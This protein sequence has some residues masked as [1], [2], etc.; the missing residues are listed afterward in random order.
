MIV[1]SVLNFGHSL[2]QAQALQYAQTYTQTLK[3]SWALYHDA[4]I[5]P[6]ASVDGVQVSPNYQVLQGGIPAP[7][8]Y[9]LHL[10]ERLQTQ[11]EQPQLLLR[12]DYPFP[13]RQNNIESPDAFQ[14][15][16]LDYLIDHPTDNFFQM[17]VAD[18]MATL[19]YAEPLVMEAS[20]VACHNTH[21]DSPRQNWQVGMVSGILTVQQ[22][23]SGIRHWVYQGTQQIGVLVG[24]L[25]GVGIFGGMMVK[26]EGEQAWQRLRDEVQQKT[27]A[28]DRLDLT[29]ALTHIANRRQCFEA[30]DKEWRRVWRQHGHLSLLLCDVDYFA[31]YNELYGTQTGDECLRAIAQTLEQQLKRAGDV[32]ARIGDDEFCIVLPETTAPEA[33]EVA[34]I[35][36]DAV[37]NLKIVHAKSDV[38]PYVSLSIGIASTSPSKSHQPED[39]LKLAEQVLHK[40]VKQL[41]RND[42]AVKLL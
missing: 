1:I 13:Q 6:L 26:M 20:C 7:A 9:F 39:L 31:D 24:V 40:D 18:D 25:A 21:A 12:S 3:T 38:S 4:V 37:H 35:I 32:V 30:L 5:Q 16:A 34:A 28:L 41:G 10:S 17:D 29:D 22:P 23:L 11:P 36:M 19:H 8:T 15:E 14:R 42:F 2:V 33:E 27:V